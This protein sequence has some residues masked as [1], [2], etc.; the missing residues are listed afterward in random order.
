MFRRVYCKI[1]QHVLVHDR[2]NICLGEYDLLVLSWT[3]CLCP[4]RSDRDS[5]F[6]FGKDS[7]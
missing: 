1:A 3:I 4:L 5:S 7:L 6:P 2:R